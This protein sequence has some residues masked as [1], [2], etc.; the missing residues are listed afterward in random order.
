MP[1]IFETLTFVTGR[2]G[3]RKGGN[4]REAG[5]SK[6]QSPP[7]TNTVTRRSVWKAWLPAAEPWMDTTELYCN[8]LAIS[9]NWGP[10]LRGTPKVLHQKE[11]KRTVRQSLQASPTGCSPE[12][13]TSP[14]RETG[15]EAGWEREQTF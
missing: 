2:K 4:K 7:F 9:E 1:C 15:T 13:R 8:S 11:A 14:G 5:V 12:N 3:R 6:R 10:K